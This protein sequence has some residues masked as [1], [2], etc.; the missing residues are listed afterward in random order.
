MPEDYQTGRQGTQKPFRHGLYFKA[1]QKPPEEV[2]LDSL[3]Q[4]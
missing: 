4:A 3:K 2:E 1:S